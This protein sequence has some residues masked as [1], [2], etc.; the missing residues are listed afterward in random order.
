M[1]PPRRTLLLRHWS[2]QLRRSHLLPP[3]TANCRVRRRI[4]VARVSSVG[5]AALQGCQG[6]VWSPCGEGLK[7][8]LRGLAKSIGVTMMKFGSAERLNARSL[9]VTAALTL[10]CSGAASA[11]QAGRGPTAD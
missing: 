1:T 7:P 6:A 3:E 10:A 5:S 2:D 8:A 9:C 11:G 4:S